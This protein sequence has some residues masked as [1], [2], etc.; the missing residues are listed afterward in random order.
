M[1]SDPRTILVRGPN[2]IGDQVLAFPFFHQLRTIYPNAKISVV[3]VPW[4]QDIQFK[5][6]VDE[7]IPLERTQS[8]VSF[9]EKFKALDR[10]ARAIGARTEWDLGISLPN[11]FSSAWLIY[12]AGAK[13]RRGYRFEGRGI[14]LNEGRD[15]PDESFGIHHRA[16][17]YVDLL[18]LEGQPEFPVRE[19]FGI[20]PDNE[21]DEVVPG[22]L[23][24]FDAD[25]HWPG[26]R[27]SPPSGPYWVIAPGATAE[28][29]R[30]PLDYFIALAKEVSE[31]TSLR[32]VIVGGPKEA[33]LAERLCQFEDLRLIDYTARGPITGLVDIFRNAEFTVTNESGLAHVA[34]FC[35]SFTQIICGAADPRRTKPI[36]P[37]MVQVSLNSV[38]CWPCEK[39]T[40]SQPSERQI[41]CLKGIK[42]ETVW[43]EIRRGLRKISG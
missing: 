5:G 6:L 17:A 34:S 20:H 28:S 33:P 42:P 30:W 43:E 15:I 21:L 25:L 12:R 29:R 36:G 19:F 37:G 31:K 38:E 14:L 39:N 32:G 3:C 8:G 22:V 10:Q 40:C 9:F 41:Q 23:D 13:K 2:W 26:P 35:G 18:R 11:S 7:V 1:R 16:Q 24:S 27:L 4:V